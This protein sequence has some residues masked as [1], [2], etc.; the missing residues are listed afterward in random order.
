MGQLTRTN[1]NFI[2]SFLDLDKDL[3]FYWGNY[4]AKLTS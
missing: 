1:Y 4:G 3:P 2:T